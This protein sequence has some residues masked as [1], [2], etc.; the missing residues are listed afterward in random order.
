[1]N[2][3]IQRALI[4]WNRDLPIIKEFLIEETMNKNGSYPYLTNPSWL[5]RNDLSVIG[6]SQAGVDTSNVYVLT[7]P[8]NIIITPLIDGAGSPIQIPS[9]LPWA[10]AGFGA[11]LLILYIFKFFAPGITTLSSVVKSGGGPSGEERTATKYEAILR[12]KEAKAKINAPPPPEP[13][14]PDLA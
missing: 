1:M 9:W 13:D 8:N 11:L 5:L 14:A 4:T 12:T 7:N 3:E 6:G 10:V 2:E